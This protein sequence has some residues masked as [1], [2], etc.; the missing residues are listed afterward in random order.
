VANKLKVG[1]IGVGGIAK[2]AHI[3]GYLRLNDKVE[4][5]ALCDIIEERAKKKANELGVTKVFTDYNEMLEMKEIDII[6]VCTPNYAHAPATIAAL[7]AGKNVICEKPMAKNAK[8]AEEMV[9]AYKKSGKILTVGY[10][11]RF[12]PDIQAL[13]SHIDAGEFG[14]IY[15][16]KAIATRR[17]GIPA[18]GDFLNMEKQG[19]GPLVDIGTHALDLTLYLMGHPE[20][21][22]VLG[23]SYTKLADKGC[24]NNFRDYDPKDYQVEDAAFGFV[25]MKNGATL[26]VETSWA[27]NLMDDE[28]FGTEVYGSGAGA[29]FHW[30]K[31]LT[32]VNESHDRINM[33]QIIRRDKIG[34]NYNAEIEHFVNCV[35]EGK[36]P[37]VKPEEALRVVK[38]QDAIYNSQKTGAAVK[39]K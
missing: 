17:R 9:K 19:G 22:T 4:I 10:Q 30:G 21:D 26:S 6:S 1:I 3:P 37:L 16:A 24:L 8:E 25:K 15:F 32:I 23:S 38:I 36:E 18:W 31:P 34:N 13:K 12:D 7:N 35:I 14:D 29:R 11:W 20:P 2:G 33:N 39:I 5:V 28:I 27:M